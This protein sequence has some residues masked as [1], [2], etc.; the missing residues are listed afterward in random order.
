[1][2]KLI[3]LLLIAFSTASVAQTYKNV[4]VPSSPTPVNDNIVQRKSGA[5]ALRTPA[6]FKTDLSLVIGDIASLTGSLAA[7]QPI[8]A[9]LTAIAAIAPT[10]DDV[11]QRKAGAWIN[12]T[13]AQ[14]KTDLGISI[15]DIATLTGPADDDVIQRKSG[16]W[17]NRTL[18]QLKTDLDP[19]ASVSKT[20]AN[21]TTAPSTP[22]SGASKLFT[23]KEAD[24][25]NLNVL[26][27]AGEVAELQQAF[28]TGHRAIWYVA[29]TGTTGTFGIIGSG[30]QTITAGTNGGTPTARSIANTNFFTQHTRVGFPTAATASSGAGLRHNST[31]Y[32]RGNGAG[33]GGFS[34]R[35]KVCYSA[36]SIAGRQGFVGFCPNGATQIPNGTDPSTLLNSVGFFADISASNNW[37]VKSNDGSGTATLAVDLGSNFPANT[38]GVDLYDMRI[39][40][41]PNDTK[42]SYWIKNLT[43]GNTASGTVTTD[44]PTSTQFL[45]WNI[46]ITN[47]ATAAV[48]AIDVIVVDAATPY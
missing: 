13:I 28:Y 26:G 36:A 44:L 5:W 2:K 39:M 35:A 16:V 46:W 9:D 41:Q 31:T 33:L 21:Q 38:N 45:G 23:K 7:L 34:L 20:Y 1:M 8:D 48:D 4:A 15:T 14:L 30:A 32:W 11:I 17:V 43:T 25:V 18:T 19:L 29:A 40:A 24:I 10:N 22:A 3:F 12:R 6:Q 37:L 47:G 27:D 42:V